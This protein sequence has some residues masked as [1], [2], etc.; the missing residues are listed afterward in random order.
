MNNF[1]ILCLCLLSLLFSVS[2]TIDEPSTHKPN[3]LLILID[4]AGWGDYG[5]HGNELVQTP[6]LDLLARQSVEIERFYVSPVCAPTRASILTGRN[7]LNTG[8]TW[9]T[10]R[11][12]VMRSEEHTIAEILKDEGYRTGLF[13][14]WHNG[15]QYPND[16]NG[17]G[18][19]RFYGF[20][21]GH[22]NN[23]FDA[24]LSYNQENISSVGYVPDLIT[25]SAIAFMNEASAPFFAMITFNTPHSPFQVPDAYFEKYQEI[26][27]SDKNACIYGM[28]ENVD[29]NIGKLLQ[30]LE[31][32]DQS[33]ETIVMFLSDNGPNGSDRYNGVLK[34]QKGQVDEG[35][36]RSAFLL[37]YPAGDWSSK[38]ISKNTFGAHIDI[39]PTI[40]ELTGISIPE[41]VDGRSMVSMIKGAV[42]DDRFFYTHQYSGKFDTIPGAIRSK[43]YLLTVTLTDTALYDLYQDEAQQ[44]D[45]SSENP[46]LVNEY[47]NKYEDWFIKTTSKGIDPELIQTGH[48]GIPMIDFPVQEANQILKAS[49][50]GGFGWANDY[51]VDWE[52][53]SLVSW[54]FMSTQSQKYQL[55]V[56]LSCSDSQGLLSLVI[57]GFPYSTHINLAIPKRLIVSP[58]RV[59]RGELYEFKWRSV[60]LGAIEIPSGNHRM[61]L[62]S[63]GLNEVEL[64]SVRLSLIAAP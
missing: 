32:H 14:K 49:Y 17:Q 11:K 29:D 33:K 4:D 64:K 31:E 22:L 15:R 19:D 16:P 35:G 24:S 20:K 7:H 46:E 52:D 30:T 6:V 47:L 41:D 26:G 39:L 27:L 48:E 9:V 63:S 59:V 53:E 54:N 34:G 37:R 40:L 61:Y 5:F 1:R 62:K 51:L 55:E 10:H 44:E 23:Y 8:T 28:M 36:V 21:E 3:V 2:C 38:R 18:F 25:D 57:D 12:E 13:G 58:D 45:L 56:F 42:D 50:K 43:Q 60:L